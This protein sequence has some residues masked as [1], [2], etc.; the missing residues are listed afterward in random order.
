MTNEQASWYGRIFAKCC[1]LQASQPVVARAE[2]YRA[3]GFPPGWGIWW[4]G[5]MIRRRDCPNFGDPWLTEM[6]RWSCK[7]QV[8]LPSVLRKMNLWPKY[9]CPRRRHISVSAGTFAENRFKVPEVHDR[10]KE[11]YR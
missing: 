1:E 11:S 10:G 9:P 2:H 6:A 5:L 3:E 8:S 7:C 4:A